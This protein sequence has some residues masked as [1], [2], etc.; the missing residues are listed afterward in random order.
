MFDKFIFDKKVKFFIIVLTHKK[1]FPKNCILHFF[2]LLFKLRNM[3]NLRYF[4]NIEIKSI[5]FLN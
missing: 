1:H 3:R 4:K 5:D 2:H